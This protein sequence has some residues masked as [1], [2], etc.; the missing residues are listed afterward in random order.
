MEEI[1]R[2]IKGIKRE[3]VIVSFA[4]MM[5]GMLMIIFPAMSGI[6]LC[7]GIG[8]AL[9]IWGA[10][11]LMAYYKVMKNEILGSFGLVQGVILLGFGI[12][13]VMKPQAIAI[14]ITTAIAIVIIVDGV[15]K[16]QYAVDFHNMNV[17]KWWVELLAALIMV[18]L[19]IVALVNPFSTMNTL[20]VFM[21]VVLVIEGAWDLA[22]IMRIS[23]AAKRFKGM[24]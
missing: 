2:K 18:G 16:L 8:V 10:L 23:A 6:L 17:D 12:F 4:L 1:L 7:K 11:R 14:F 5:L 21:G 3:L 13:F 15:L 19:G 20:M 9:C 24:L 22:A